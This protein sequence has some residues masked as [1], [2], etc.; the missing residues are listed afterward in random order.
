VV[1][2]GCT[3]DSFDAA[4]ADG[5]FDTMGALEAAVAGGDAGSPLVALE[6]PPDRPQP[7]RPATAMHVARGRTFI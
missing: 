1:G 4:E 5:A 3:R 2:A 7:T 6:T